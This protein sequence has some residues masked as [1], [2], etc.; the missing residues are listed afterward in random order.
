[1]SEVNPPKSNKVDNVNHPSHYKGENGIECI[2]AMEAA[3][4]KEAVANFCQCNAFKYLFNLFFQLSN[5]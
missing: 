2:D 4:G 1:M 3:F 5:W